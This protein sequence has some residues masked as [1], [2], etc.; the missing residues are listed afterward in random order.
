MAS[1]SYSSERAIIASYTRDLPLPPGMSRLY[2]DMDPL[3]R[4]FCSEDNLTGSILVA[5]VMSFGRFRFRIRHPDKIACMDI[6]TSCN[7][8]LRT[9]FRH[10]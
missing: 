8:R 1:D 3:C 5:V 9:N 6:D 10:E 2:S 4:K 7:I